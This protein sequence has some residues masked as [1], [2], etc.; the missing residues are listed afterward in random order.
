MPMDDEVARDGFRYCYGRFYTDDNVERIDGSE[1]ER[2]FLP[3]LT[4]EANNLLRHH[5]ANFVRSQLMHYGIEYDPTELT[6]NGTNLLKRALE[7]GLCDTVPNHIQRLRS[8]MHAEWLAHCSPKDLA[9]HPRWIMEKYF[10]DQSGKPD[11]TK[12]TTVVSVPFGRF[13]S[14]YNTS[15]LEAAADRVPGLHQAAERGCLSET[16]YLGWDRRAV[17]QAADNHRAKEAQEYQRQRDEREA[18]RA[19]QHADFL[20]SETNQAHG[21]REYSIIG[22][23]IIDCEDIES[24]WPEQAEEDMTLEIKI[25]NEKSTNGIYEATFDFGITEGIMILSA[26]KVAL[27]EYCSLLE[28][29]NDYNSDEDE[30]AESEDEDSE[31]EKADAGTTKRAPTSQGQPPEKKQNPPAN[32]LEYFFCLKCSDTG[33]GEVDF[34]PQKGTMKFNDQMLASFTGIVTDL[35]CVGAGVSFTGRKVDSSSLAF[36]ASWDDYSEAAHNRAL[37]GRWR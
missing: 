27:D 36:W 21:A 6:G 24:G 9:R 31:E 7:A 29:R 19:A 37:V 8:E 35:F 12:T 13:S 1:L 26:D 4:P 3:R 30:D 32:S 25:S 22:H 34:T 11:P 18:E 5:H 10:L 20:A 23:Y 28:S 17:N 14:H 16:I 2:M 15:R 33:T